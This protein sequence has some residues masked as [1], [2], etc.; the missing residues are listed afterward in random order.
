MKRTLFF[1]FIGILFLF[2]LFVGLGTKNVE[3]ETLKVES[4]DLNE[5]YVV[6]EVGQT[7]VLL[8]NIYPFNANNQNVLWSSS[9][10]S[11]VSVEDGILVAKNP[12]NVTIS[13]ISNEGGFVDY[14]YVDVI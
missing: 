2:G 7:E 3:V 6:L 8:A 5:E 1:S 10:E 14:C 13:A 11:V 9:N 12:G 4:L